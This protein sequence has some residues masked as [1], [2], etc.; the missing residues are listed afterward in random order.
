[1]K[2]ADTIR[3]AVPPPVSEEEA[4]L[5]TFLAGVH[6]EVVNFDNTFDFGVRPVAS[7]PSEIDGSPAQIK[8]V[9]ASCEKP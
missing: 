4:G 7:P 3:E 5:I 2:T 9:K 8:L 1:M 6:R